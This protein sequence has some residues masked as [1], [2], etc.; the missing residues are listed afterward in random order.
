MKKRSLS[1]KQQIDAAWKTVTTL[2]PKPQSTPSTVVQNRPFR[3][4]L[5]ERKR[6][7]LKRNAND[8]N[9]PLLERVACAEE[10]GWLVEQVSDT[11]Y[12]VMTHN[13]LEFDI[14]DV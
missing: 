11:V 9:R 5:P 14:Y 13:F 6:S 12:H 1:K 3:A 7:E 4:D 10:L 2:K 8:R